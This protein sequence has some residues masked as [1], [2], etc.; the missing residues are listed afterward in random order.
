MFAHADCN[1]CFDH[2]DHLQSCSNEPG[3]ALARQRRR[4]ELREVEDDLYDRISRRVR[5]DAAAG[6]TIFKGVMKLICGFGLASRSLS[7]TWTI[8]DGI[9]TR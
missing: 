9:D 8:L 3:L 4:R 2:R 1:T 6:S 5:R 7:L